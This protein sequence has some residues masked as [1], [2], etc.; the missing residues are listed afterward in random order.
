M[1]SWTIRFSGTKNSS[2]PQQAQQDSDLALLTPIPHLWKCS[3]RS[4]LIRER[5]DGYN[6][7]PRTCR[8][9]ETFLKRSS[10]SLEERRYLGR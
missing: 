3:W 9:A 1:I 10:G 5:L 6:D 4:V 7:Q 8:H 2:L